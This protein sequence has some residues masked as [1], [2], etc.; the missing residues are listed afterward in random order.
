M[1]K[2]ACATAV[3]AAMLCACGGGASSQS[4]FSPC[5]VIFPHFKQLYPIP[6]STGVPATVKLIVFAGNDPAPPW[7]RGGGRTIYTKRR[8]LPQPLPQPALSAPPDTMTYAASTPALAPR[9]TYKVLDAGTVVTCESG[10]PAKTVH[11]GSFTTR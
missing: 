2:A 7:L 9:T 5:Y 6:G 3:L 10:L 11:L 1:I 8:A 4:N